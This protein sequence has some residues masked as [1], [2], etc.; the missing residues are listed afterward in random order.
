MIRRSFL[1]LGSLG[2]ILTV[3]ILMPGVAVHSQDLTRGQL[4][5]LAPNEQDLQ[6]FI[7][8]L[9]GSD[10][11]SRLNN[12]DP[13]VTPEVPAQSIKDAIFLRNDPTSTPYWAFVFSETVSVGAIKRLFQSADG[14]FNLDIDVIL[15]DTPEAAHEQLSHLHWTAGM[16]KPGRWTG[17][18][19]IGDESLALVQNGRIQ[20]LAFRY[21]SLLA[22]IEGSRSNR[23]F[24]SNR[25]LTIQ[26]MP[27]A[28][29]EAIAYQ[30]V[31][32]A[33]QQAKLVTAPTQNTRLAVNGHVLPKNALLV[34]KQTYVPV[35]E[36]AKAMNLTS[37][38]DAKTGALTLTGP[39]R[40][41]VALTAGSTAATVGGVKVA[42]L[43]VPVLKDGGEPV[44][45]LSD[46]LALTGGRVTGHAGN[47][48]Q[49][50]G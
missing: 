17:P 16:W 18:E 13:N 1:S 9:P 41:T 48:V 8:V 29:V 36:F 11:P 21:G 35:R 2:L 10:A 34:G 25:T 43:A 39:K 37:G 12:G 26:T 24:M 32:R 42:A 7:R 3:L 15:C 5:A 31:L 38:W 45:A 47:T 4:Q 28:A 19:M 6:G 33:S 40:K 20:T 27:P 44:M 14:T 46:L 23:S 30:I 22:L 50:K 49:V